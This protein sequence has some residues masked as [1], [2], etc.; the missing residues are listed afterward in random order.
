M[1]LIELGLVSFNG[2]YMSIHETSELTTVHNV[3]LNE[4]KSPFTIYHSKSGTLS[5]INKCKK[6]KEG[7]FAQSYIVIYIFLHFTN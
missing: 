2:V 5:T 4:G 1:F 7:S 3:S 6:G